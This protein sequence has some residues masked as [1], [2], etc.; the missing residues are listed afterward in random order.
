M[1]KA[2]QHFYRATPG[3]T[4]LDRSFFTYTVLTPE[5]G[6]QALPTGVYELLPKGI[7]GL[8]LGRSSTTMLGIIVAPGIIDA[9]CKGNIKVKVYSPEEF[10]L[11]IQGKD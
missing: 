3:S 5:M 11:L 6:V 7:V 4:E 2:I 10:Q 8:M 1:R 9:D